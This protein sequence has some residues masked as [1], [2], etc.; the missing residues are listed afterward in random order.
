[1]SFGSS[2]T[3]FEKFCSAFLDIRTATVWPYSRIEP[4]RPALDTI[5]M[6]PVFS[7]QLLTLI[8]NVGNPASFLKW[9]NST[10]L[11]FGL[12]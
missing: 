10:T 7:I 6:A 9:S 8:V 12:Y 2:D 5:P 11:K 3:S 1:M 4:Y